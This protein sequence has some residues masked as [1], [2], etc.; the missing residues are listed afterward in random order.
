MLGKEFFDSVRASL[1]SGSLNPTQVGMLT[2]LDKAWTQHGDGNVASEAYVMSTVF[3]EL[4]SSLISR[5][6]NLDYSAERAHEVWPRKF[7]TAAAAAPYAHNPVALA[8]HVYAKIDG[9]RDEASGDGWMFRG[10]GPSQLTGRA[11]YTKFSQLLGLDLINHPDLA[12]DQDTGSAI[13]VT[14]MVIGRFTGKKLSDYFGR[15]GI[16]D[17]PVHARAIVNGDV[18]MNGPKI[19]VNWQKFLTALKAHS[20]VAAPVAPVP[21]PAPVPKATES[22]AEVLKSSP[23]SPVSGIFATLETVK[24][25]LSL[26]SLLLNLLP[27]IPMLEQDFE[28]EVK[29]LASSEDGKTKAIQTLHLL[30]D[31]SK[32]L[33]AALG[34]AAP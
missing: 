4:S 33:R 14:G 18:A 10:R 31:A 6:E 2:A 7:P 26:F 19:A 32:K 9:N 11:N 30:E 21:V 20:S 3:N 17:D 34:D 27:V 28:L 16:A 15:P 5:A 24:M 8:N 23:L 1:F 29:N 22:V 12:L 25:N 13:L